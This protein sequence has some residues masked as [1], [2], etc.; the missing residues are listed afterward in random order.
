LFEQ[1]IQAI[2]KEMLQHEQAEC[3]VVH[4]FGPG[5]YIR[6]VTLPAG[7]VAI[8]HYQK[9]PHLNVMLAGKVSL[10]N[11]DNTLSLL[12]AP[13]TLLMPPGRKVGY[14]HETVVWQNIFATDETDVEK[15][16]EMF[17]EKSNTFLTHQQEKLLLEATIKNEDHEDYQQ[18]LKEFGF[19]EE[20]A[21]T[22]SENLEDQRG[23][24][25]GTYAF[26]VG[27]SKIEGKGIIA[28]GNYNEGEVIGECRI[29][30]LRTPLGRYTNHSKTPN[31]KPIIQENGDI[32]LVATKKIVGNK[33][34][35]DGEEIT[36]D[37]R[38]ALKLAGI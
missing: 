33:G 16:E 4:R 19:T 25:H 14:I 31:A 37:Y 2:E 5:I 8:G 23:M 6:E 10:V 21:R 13:L 34:G 22:Q 26:K 38:E 29:N 12:E 20:I 7:I 24:P 9:T 27:S 32:Y 15:L 28:T 36:I 30:G 11:S 1:K 35:Q 18:V 17:I 3:S